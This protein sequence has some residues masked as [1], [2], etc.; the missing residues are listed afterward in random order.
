MSIEHVVSLLGGLALFLYGMHMMSD[1]LEHAAGDQMK[2]ILQKITSNR[3]LGVLVGA[4]ITAVIQSSSATTVMVVGFVNSKLMTLSQAV[5]LIMGANIGT[6]I[7]G[8]LLTLNVSTIAPVVAIIGVVLVTFIKNK[9]ANA[10]GLI[11]AGLGFLFIGMDIMKDAMV[12]LRDEP[13]FINLLT[14]ISNPFL[15]VLFGAGFTAL[16]QSSSASVGILQTLAASGLIGLDSSIYIIFGQNIGTC[17]TSVLASLSGNRDSKRATIIHLSFN[18]IGTLLFMIAIQFIPFVDLM[19][20]ITSAPDA[21]IANT[22]TIFNIVTTLILLPFGTKLAKLPTYILP[23]LPS[24]QAESGIVPLTFVDETNL[25]SVSIAISSLRKEALSMLQLSEQSVLQTIK[26][27][28]GDKVDHDEIY[29]R[30]KHIN[31]INFQVTQY[32]SKVSLLEKNEN[33]ANTINS[34][35]KTFA[36]IERIGDHALNLCAYSQAESEMKLE[37]AKE[38]KVELENL[39]DLINQAFRFIY[40][41]DFNKHMDGFDNV[42]LIENK[43]D[44]LTIAYRQNQLNR[45]AENKVSANDTV[46]Y[47]EILTDIERISDHL[48]NIIEECRNNKFTISEDLFESGIQAINQAS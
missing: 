47:S 18:L 15:A 28:Y 20:S 4:L 11:M 10:I 29:K 27:L 43:I 41:Y 7:T 40:T 46:V 38:M 44:D 6:T 48:M 37:D 3:F 45:L 24:E 2:T 42:E 39:Y 13:L 32:M 12:P 8:Q 25:G 1:G 34:L 31:Q 30:E 16:I 35:Y 33:Q 22:H 21:Q 17:I 5:W 23:V 14:T 36:D 9:K 19:Q 26:A